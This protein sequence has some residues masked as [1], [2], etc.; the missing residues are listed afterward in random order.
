M[1]CALDPIYGAL[2]I[3]ADPR[4]AD[5]QEATLLRSLGRA[6]RHLNDELAKGAAASGAPLLETTTYAS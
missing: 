5:T 6:L 2:L 4:A 1:Q 3:C